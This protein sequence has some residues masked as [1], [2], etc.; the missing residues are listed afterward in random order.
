MYQ[1][2]KELSKTTCVLSKGLGNQVKGLPSAQIRN[3]LS[4]KKSNYSGFT[5]IK[6]VPV[7]KM[8]ELKIQ[9][10]SLEDVGEPTHSEHCPR[11]GMNQTF[12]L[13]FLI[14]YLI[15][16]VDEEKSLCRRTF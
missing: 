5:H 12:I 1:K 11:K 16:T 8:R 2:T 3:N 14:G 4:I 6:Y 15:Q 10:F 9:W 7:C 13:S